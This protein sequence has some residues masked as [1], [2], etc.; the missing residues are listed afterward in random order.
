MLTDIDDWSEFD[1][2]EDQQED[3]K[4][5]MA[6]M[7]RLHLMMSSTWCLASNVPLNCHICDYKATTKYANIE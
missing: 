4:I 5:I 3:K 6:G 1:F 2:L 7:K